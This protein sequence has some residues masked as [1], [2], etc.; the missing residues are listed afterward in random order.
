MYSGLLEKANRPLM[1]TH[2]L[3]GIKNDMLCD[4]VIC[5]I[6]FT[7]SLNH[8]GEHVMH[9]SDMPN[10]LVKTVGGRMVF[11]QSL[12]QVCLPHFSNCPD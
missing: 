2:R 10:E 11:E 6:V 8:K 4:C 9:Q 5:S 3:R 7:F 1:Y 12:P